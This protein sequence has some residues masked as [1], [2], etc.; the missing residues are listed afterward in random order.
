MFVRWNLS[1]IS[2]IQHY[3]SSSIEFQ[4]AMMIL[5][6]MIKL[7]VLPH[8]SKSFAKD[9]SLICNPSY[10]SKITGWVFLMMEAY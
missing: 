8:L 7:Q 9:P 10:V 1:L 2:L 5:V 3:L 4:I 6:P